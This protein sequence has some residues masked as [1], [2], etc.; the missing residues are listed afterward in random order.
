MMWTLGDC[1]GT[2]S[3]ENVFNVTAFI[4]QWSR[5][6]KI[7]ESKV[8]SPTHRNCPCKVQQ[9]CGQ[10]R[11]KVLPLPGMRVPVIPM[12]HCLGAAHFRLAGLPQRPWPHTERS[13]QFLRKTNHSVFASHVPQDTRARPVHHVT[14]T[15]LA[16]KLGADLT[17]VEL[18]LCQATLEL[19][20]VSVH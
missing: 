10:S 5:Y 3:R 1:E 6:I 2:G 17:S 9:V 13:I 11:R 4:A 12:T 16:V 20:F 8:I 18:S 14:Y 15:D 19:P 7:I